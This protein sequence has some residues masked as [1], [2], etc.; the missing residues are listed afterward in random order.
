MSAIDN[1]TLERFVQQ[2]SSIDETAIA[3]LKGH[4]LIEEKI[5]SIISLFVFHPKFIEQS[6]LFL[7]KN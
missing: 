1:D 3:V 6:R 4:L 7:H 2:F 5:D